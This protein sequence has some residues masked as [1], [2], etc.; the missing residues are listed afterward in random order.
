MTVTARQLLISSSLMTDH[1]VRISVEDTGPGIAPDSHDRVFERF[2]TTRSAGM[3]IGL[4]ICRTIIEAHRG[5]I[6]LANR[7]NARGAHFKLAL[8][9]CLSKSAS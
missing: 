1:W 4:P 3:G 7:S 5:R 8:P 2:F 6:E 9:S